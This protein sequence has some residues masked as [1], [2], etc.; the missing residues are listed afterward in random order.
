MKQLVT[1][2]DTFRAINPDFA[3]LERLAEIAGA[4]PFEA[5]HCLGIIFEEDRE[6]WAIHGWRDNPQIVIRE[7]LKG[8]NA[9]REEAERVVNLLVA[10]GHH[11]F[12]QLLKQA[13]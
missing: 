3:V 13:I 12:R 4:Y 2:L 5:V 9:S 10:R 1:V 8:D 11:G 6:G 7:A